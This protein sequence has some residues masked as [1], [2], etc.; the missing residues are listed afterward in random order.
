MVLLKMVGAIRLAYW[1]ATFRLRRTLL[2]KRPC[3]PDYLLNSYLE[4]KQ[5]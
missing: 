5:D 2:N 3:I 4:T 1:R